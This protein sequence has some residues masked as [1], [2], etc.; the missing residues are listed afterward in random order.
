ML[1]FGLGDRVQ[2]KNCQSGT[3][4]A[5]VSQSY[6]GEQF[7]LNFAQDLNTQL[8]CINVVPVYFNQM[9]AL[10]AGCD[11]EKKKALAANLCSRCMIKIQKV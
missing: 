10:I 2:R 5:R 8:H 7:A 6:G 4:Q 11:K 9:L 3:V 1:D